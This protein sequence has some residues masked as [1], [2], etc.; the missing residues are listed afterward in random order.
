EA[1]D[2]ADALPPR[3]GGWTDVCGQDPAIAPRAYRAVAASLR[4]EQSRAHR[5]LGEAFDLA[6][7]SG[8]PYDEM[9]VLML[10]AWV[11]TLERDPGAGG[12]AAAGFRLANE[13][14]FA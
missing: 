13:R 6:S 3:R 14:S 5:L 10:G 2:A 8:N 11:Q 4:A 1:A 12:H 7:R 9:F